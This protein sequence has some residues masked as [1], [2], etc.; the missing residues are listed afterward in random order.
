[1][2]YPV[3]WVVSLIFIIQMYLMMFVLAL[4]FIPMTAIK[5]TG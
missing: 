1:M 4:F 2:P 3:R 5:R